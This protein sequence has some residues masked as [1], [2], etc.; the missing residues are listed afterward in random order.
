MENHQFTCISDHVQSKKL[1]GTGLTTVH[2]FQVRGDPVNLAEM[3]NV[4][5][6][7]GSP[8]GKNGLLMTNHVL[9]DWVLFANL[10]KVRWFFTV[11][12][13]LFYL[14]YDVKFIVT[15]LETARKY[16]HLIIQVLTL[17]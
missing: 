10:Q 6:Y 7:Y 5:R 12:S 15:L 1:I 8:T 17:I 9:I 14:K 11:S 13:T 4:G 16:F 2:S 3:D